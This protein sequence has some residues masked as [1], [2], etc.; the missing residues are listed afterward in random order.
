[1]NKLLTA[2]FVSAFALTAVPSFA[3]SHA[4]AMPAASAPAKAKAKAKAKKEKAAKPMAAKDAA[5][6]A[7]K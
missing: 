1:M 6:G 4:G 2:L 7:K 3:A 5:S